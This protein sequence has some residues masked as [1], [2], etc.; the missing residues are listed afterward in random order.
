[1]AHCDF[2]DAILF[3]DVPPT[4][5]APFRFVRIQ[6]LN[7]TQEYSHFIL[8]ELSSLVHTPFVLIIQW[9]GYVLEPKAWDSRFRAY[10]LIGARWNWRK[11]GVSV[12]NG[13]FTLRSHKLLKAMSEDR[14]EFVPALNEDDQICC[15]HRSVLINE[16]GIRFAPEDIADRFAYESTTP[17]LPTFGFHGVFNLW[18]HTEDQEMIA[19]A[20]ELSPRV[21]RSTEFLNLLGQ[22]FSMRKFGPLRALYARMKEAYSSEEIRTRISE[23]T[24][25]PGLAGN[26]VAINEQLLAF[27]V[28]MV[29]TS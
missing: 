20:A 5:A 3:S 24:K 26:F 7:S 11:E 28:D 1:M 12:G 29:S 9:D 2:G 18:R 6:R 4:D 8:K 23:V 14:F 10:D 25:N 22:Y 13:G 19:M 27:P 17:A 21:I 16:F 15:V